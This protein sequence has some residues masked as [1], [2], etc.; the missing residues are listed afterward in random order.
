MKRTAWIFAVYT[1]QNAG[2]A[3]K[4]NV[5]ACNPHAITYSN[6]GI[7]KLPEKLHT[8]RSTKVAKIASPPKTVQYYDDKI[9]FLIYKH[10]QAKSDKMPKVYDLYDRT[11]LVDRY[12]TD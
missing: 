12:Q 5:A 10:A 2:S 7:M 3:S 6:A 8:Q 1:Y 9:S 11:C 4:V